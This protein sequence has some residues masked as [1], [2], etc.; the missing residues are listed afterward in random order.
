MKTKKVHSLAGRVIW[1]IVIPAVAIPMIL[2]AYFLFTS[3]KSA[4]S[5]TVYSDLISLV[6]INTAFAEKL[7]ENGNNRAEL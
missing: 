4:I 6:E 2:M 5:D 1:L 3:F 7:I